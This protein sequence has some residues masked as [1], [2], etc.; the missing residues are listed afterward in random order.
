MAHYLKIW[1]DEYINEAEIKGGRIKL[2]H[3]ILLVTSNYLPK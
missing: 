2:N 3:E 1:A